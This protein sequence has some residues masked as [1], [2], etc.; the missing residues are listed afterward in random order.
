MSSH[1]SAM[2]DAVIALRAARRE[3]SKIF[4]YEQGVERNGK[5]Q[6]HSSHAALTSAYAKNGL[7]MVVDQRLHTAAP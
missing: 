6:R 1:E 4:V 7:H 2:Q 5:Q 3:D